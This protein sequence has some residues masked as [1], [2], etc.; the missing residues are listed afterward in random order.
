[1]LTKTRMQADGL[2]QLIY[3]CLGHISHRREEIKKLPD[4][5]CEEGIM[6]SIRFLTCWDEVNLD[7]SGHMSRVA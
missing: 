5:F 4:K 6:A 7:T 2:L 3:T 1:P